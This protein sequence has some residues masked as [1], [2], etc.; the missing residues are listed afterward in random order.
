MLRDCLPQA[1]K[2]FQSS[3]L[4]PSRP[5]KN[6]SDLSRYETPDS[7]WEKSGL[8][9]REREDAEHLKSRADAPQWWAVYD[10]LRDELGRGMMSALVG[11][12]GGGKT[13]MAAK[14][15]REACIAFLAMPTEERCFREP[16]YT[17]AP[18]MF[19]E[20]MRAQQNGDDEAVMRKYLR[21]TLLAIDEAHER[22]DTEA[23]DRRMREII[24][25]RYKRQNDTLLITN[26]RPDE[27][28]KAIGGA[29][30]DRIRQ[31][32]GII[33]CSWGSFRIPKENCQ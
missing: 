18:M 23:Q 29:A 12:F 32:G 8:G 17:T 22:P 31:C 16:M 28:A 4:Q 19:R 25:Q 9:K 33:P 21:P 13:V 30:I 1:I 3:M 26:M 20:L 6:W 7:L 5:E 14:L 27:L 15:L 2:L 11:E 24:D 10:F